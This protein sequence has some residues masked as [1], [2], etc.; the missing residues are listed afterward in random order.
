VT[1]S[2]GGSVQQSGNALWVTDPSTPPE[3]AS[4]VTA[5]LGA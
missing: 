1:K 4:Q 5:C 3:I 2:S